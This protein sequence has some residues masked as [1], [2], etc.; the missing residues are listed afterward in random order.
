[1]Q[2]I[3]F[4]WGFICCWNLVKCKSAFFYWLNFT[5]KWN[6]KIWKFE[7]KKR[8]RWLQSFSIARSEGKI[9]NI[10]H[11]IYIFGFFVC[12]QKYRRMLQ[13]V[14]FIFGLQKDLVKSSK[15]WLPLFL[16]LHLGGWHF[17][18]Q[19]KFLKEITGVNMV[20]TLSFVFMVYS[21]VCSGM[22]SLCACFLMCDFVNFDI[23]GGWCS[24]AWHHL[25][26]DCNSRLSWFCISAKLSHHHVVSW[27]AFVLEP[28]QHIIIFIIIW[29]WSL[30][31]SL[32]DSI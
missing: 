11:Q 7:E 15:G 16:H 8:N 1:L 32:K 31:N 27:K 18:Y 23:G 13:D 25:Q 12:S 6:K 2:S 24:T 14:Y 21:K 20:L 19:Q 9:K 28:W 29:F 4:L 3:R 17:G 26:W 30:F 5:K 22:S 10:N